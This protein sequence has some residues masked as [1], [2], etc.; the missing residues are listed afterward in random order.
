MRIVDQ[1]L[2]FVRSL[3]YSGSGGFHAHWV[4]VTSNTTTTASAQF[5]FGPANQRDPLLDWARDNNLATAAGTVQN[6]LNTSATAFSRTLTYTAFNL[7]A[8]IA[9]WFPAPV[10]CLGTDGFGRSDT[11]AKLREFF[12]VNRHFIVLASLRALADE[13]LLPAAKVGEAIRQYGIDPSK[14]Y[15]MTA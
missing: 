4:R 7:P 10:H 14:S 15:P 2:T 9:H 11:R 5:T 12:E 1:G 13:G 8:T 6:R 3:V